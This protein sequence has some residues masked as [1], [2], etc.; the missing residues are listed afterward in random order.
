[1]QGP[2]PAGPLLFGS[3]EDCSQHSA[4]K[5]HFFVL[6]RPAATVTNRLLVHAM[7]TRELVLSFSDQMYQFLLTWE[8]PSR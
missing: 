8:F 2:R 4:Q 3:Q 7:Q 5:T 1:M 6:K